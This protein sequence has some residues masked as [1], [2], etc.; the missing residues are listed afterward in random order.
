MNEFALT[1]DS[2]ALTKKDAR[3]KAHDF[4]V[5][6][7]PPL[8]LEPNVEYAMALQHLS[9]TA[10]WYNIRSEYG[11]DKLV[12]SKDGGSSWT[13]L[14]FTPG[15]YD[16][17][18]LNSVL[19]NELGA[20]KITI[21]FNQSTFKVLIKLESG[22]Q[23]DFSKSG[24]LNELLGFLNTKLTSSAYGSKVPNLTNSVDNLYL[25]CSLLSESNLNGERSNVL[26]SFAT[27]TKSRALPFE[28]IPQPNYF[29]HRIH[30]TQIREI[31]FWF[32]DGVNRVVDLNGLSVSLMVVIKRMV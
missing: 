23:I 2:E 10:S 3:N 15:I 16:Y 19:S 1:I 17:E 6:Y 32:E 14:T 22:F 29:W 4:T 13:T 7:Q 5:R 25:R 31:R 21:F 30:E 8:D 9:M 28:I 24:T 12:V 18:D 27:N 11:N 26:F 20:D